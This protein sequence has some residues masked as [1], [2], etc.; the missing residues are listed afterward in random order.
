MSKDSSVILIPHGRDESNLFTII[1]DKLYSWSDE[2]VQLIKIPFRGKDE[3]NFQVNNFESNIK[4][5][6][7]RNKDVL[8]NQISE[9]TINDFINK[10]SINWVVIIDSD[11]DGQDLEKQKRMMDNKCIDQ[12]ILAAKILLDT[13]KEENYSN[14]NVVWNKRSLEKALKMH[15]KIIGANKGTRKYEL[16][17]TFK[18]MIKKTSSVKQILEILKSEDSNFASVIEIIAID[19]F[20]LSVD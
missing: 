3:I 9:P 7:D 18:Q 16:N 2:E 13:E 20:K 17:T 5:V 10:H 11:E 6:I 12:I 19:V 1:F 15:E 8:L 14:R 4:R